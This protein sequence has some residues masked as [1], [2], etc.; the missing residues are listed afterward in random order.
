MEGRLVSTIVDGV[1][2]QGS[3]EVIFQNK[4]YAAGSYYAR[5]QNGSV[6]QVHTMM[7]VK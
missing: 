1:Q 2:D 7:L 4:G 3:H 5:L 6:Q